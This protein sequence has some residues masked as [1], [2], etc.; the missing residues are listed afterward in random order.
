MSWQLDELAQGP[1]TPFSVDVDPWLRRVRSSLAEAGTAADLGSRESDLVAMHQVV[2]HLLD[3][4]RRLI[5]SGAD[6]AAREQAGLL[7]GAVALE[8][9]NL[10]TGF[11]T[12]R[13]ATE[14]VPRPTPAPRSWRSLDAGLLDQT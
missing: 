14:Q 12:D 10:R 4:R 2:G 7:I 1:R 8:Y 6:K 3:L 13:A 5:D 11:A 9:E